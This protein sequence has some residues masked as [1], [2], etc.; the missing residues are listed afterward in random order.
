MST[1]SVD[2]KLMPRRYNAEAT[3]RLQEKLD[4]ATQEPD[5]VT[6][7]FLNATKAFI[8]EGATQT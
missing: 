2:A 6:P 5:Y 7:E 4:S 8:L 3:R 1:V